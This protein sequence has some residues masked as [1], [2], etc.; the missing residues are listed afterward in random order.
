MKPA[1][2]NS[3]KKSAEFL[4]FVAPAVILICISALIPFVMSLYYSFTRW[5]GIGKEVAFVGFRNF[6]EIFTEDSSALQSM[7]FTFK[8]SLWNVVLTNVL[9]I[10]LALALTKALRSANVLRAVFFLP[11]IVSLVIIGFVWKFIFSKVFESL[12]QWTGFHVFQWSWLGDVDL[13]F[14]SVLFVNVWQSVGF[15]MMIYITGLQA[16]PQDLLEA[17][18]VDGVGGFAKF[19]RVTLPLLMPSL[20]VAVFLSIANSLKIFDVIYTLTYGGP[21]DATRSITM[22][23]YTE[24]FVNNRFGYATAKSL[25]FVLI[26]LLITVV[27]VKFFKSREV[28]A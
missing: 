14:V 19:F 10:L 27:Q 15:F 13:A 22:D 12:H 20:T 9:A 7:L 6:V 2:S 3:W 23:I 21:G 24:A 5:N 4:C 11:N 1:V 26:V 16:I 17:A 8:F 28:E 18:D 25:I